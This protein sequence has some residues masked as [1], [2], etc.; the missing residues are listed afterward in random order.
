[1]I[2]RQTKIIFIIAIGLLLIKTAVSAAIFWWPKNVETT[3]GNEAANTLIQ[4]TNAYRRGLGLSE[5]AINPRLTQ[6]AINKAKDILAKQYFN[7][8]SPEG[9]KFSD[10][11]KEVNYSYFYVGENLAIDFNNPQDVFDAWLA[12][13]AHKQNIERQEFQEI[14]LADLSGE[15]NQRNTSVVVQLFG[16]RVLGENE[17]TAGSTQR[18]LI[19]NYYPESAEGVKINNLLKQINPQL[20]YLLFLT[21]IALIAAYFLTRKSLYPVKSK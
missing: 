9:K 6:A 20:D 12:S 16:S 15:F 11:I 13:P 14:G 19:D 21:I 8:T 3:G 1:M 2:S 17:T 10:W 18:P 7:H 5:L 4:L